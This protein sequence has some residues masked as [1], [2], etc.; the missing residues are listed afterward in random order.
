MEKIMLGSKINDEEVQI[1]T[2]EAL[3]DIV[4]VNYD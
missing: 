1:S 4:R 3:G 2:M